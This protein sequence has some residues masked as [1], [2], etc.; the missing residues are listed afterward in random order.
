M[1]STEI[2]I[3][4]AA[5]A[6]LGFFCVPWQ[7]HAARPTLAVAPFAYS[8]ANTGHGLAAVM[9]RELAYGGHFD[10]I[11]AQ[12]AAQALEA[13]GFEA[14]PGVYAEIAPAQ[15]EPLNGLADYLLTAEVSA[16]DTARKEPA[17]DL[18]RKLSGLGKRSGLAS[19]I[20]QV[21]L[22]FRLLRMSDGQEV[23]AFTVE[24]LES[25]RGVAVDVTQGWLSATNYEGD[26]FR[27]TS[28]GRAFYKAVGQALYELYAE[29]PL[30]GGVLAVTGDSVVI[31]LD[32][33]AGVQIGD[34]MLILRDNP[35]GN[36][37]G[38]TVW[39]ELQR[40][41]S[42][43]VVEFQPGRCLCLVLDGDGVIQE[44]D[45]ARPLSERLVLPIETGHEDQP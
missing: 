15:L 9:A 30:E 16:F 32:Q 14:K 35:I 3:F 41:G 2:K 10:L 31:D 27:R 8:S 22:E 38:E 37:L 34:E 12:R 11:S 17:F 28:L 24:G 26:E 36:T 33:R 23:L 20:A 25:R 1:T 45:V 43:K 29:F 19:K 21:V 6:L 5:L 44:G 39:R 13:A 42:A 7:A 40:V 4:V 18:G